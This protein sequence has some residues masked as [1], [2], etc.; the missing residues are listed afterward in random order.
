ML[1]WELDNQEG[2]GELRPTDELMEMSFESLES[3]TCIQIQVHDGST[4]QHRIRAAS[5]RLSE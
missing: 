3:C 5:A 1:S 2:L 4:A